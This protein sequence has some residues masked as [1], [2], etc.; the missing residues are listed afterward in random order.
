MENTPSKHTSSSPEATY[1]PQAP[2]SSPP[3]SPIIT[4]HPARLS[5]SFPVTGIV[6]SAASGAHYSGGS[7]MESAQHR[8]SST[9]QAK[10]DDGNEHPDRKELMDALKEL[11]CCRPTIEIFERWWDPNAVF[12]DPLANAHGFDQYAPQWFGMPRIFSKSETLSARI[13]SSTRSPNRLIYS[14]QQ[15]Y[16]VRYTGSKKVIDSVVEVDLNEDDKITHMVEKWGGN[17]PPSGY[18]AN[19]LRGMNT[20]VIP[21]LVKIPKH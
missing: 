18:I 20:R 14:Q 12:E 17:D 1:P 6:H 3:P 13:M 4:H 15:E 10:P 9:S 5:G 19:L 21:W 7:V 8:T 16:I 2:S 11:Y